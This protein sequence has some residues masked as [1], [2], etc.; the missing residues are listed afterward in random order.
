MEGILPILFCVGLVFL[1]Y[2]IGWV[3]D[4]IS[5][6]I[7]FRNY[8]KL[9][10][11]LE[12]QIS[13]FNLTKYQK[14]TNDIVV[15]TADNDLSIRAVYFCKKKEDHNSIL[16]TCLFTYNEGRARMRKPKKQSY[17]RYRYRRYY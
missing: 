8:K 2:V 13:K 5:R 11:Q 12:P 4:K 16:D 15:K 14:L 7:E 1:F 6:F 9:L 3:G 17:R 10:C